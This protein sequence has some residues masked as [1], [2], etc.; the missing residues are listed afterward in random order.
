MKEYKKQ[1]I[2]TSVITVIPMLIGLLLWNR[3]PN[4]IATHFGTGNV[5]NGWSSKIFTVL[6]MPVMLLAIHLFSVLVTL[7][8]PKKQNIGKKM[9]TF[10]FWIVPIVSLIV[11]LSIYGYALKM[12]VNI[13]MFANLIVG[14]VFIVS[15]N[16]MSKNRQNY[17]VGIKL[18]W[19]LNSQE[20]WNRTHRLASKLWILAGVIA[21]ID[22]FLDSVIVIGVTI[23][24]LVVIPMAYSFILY[25][26][27]I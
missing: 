16:Y 20:N 25:K 14:L 17:T 27:G 3:L 2:L 21:I 6:G 13:G 22:I 11:S 9:L 26:K 18:P 15:G 7:N 8:D 19:T 5:P 24:V 1:I 12:P 23:A 4:T 10:V